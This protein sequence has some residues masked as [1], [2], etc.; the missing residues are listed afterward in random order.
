MNRITRAIGIETSK[1]AARALTA[2]ESAALSRA[3]NMSFEEYCVLQELKSLAFSERRFNLEEAE[4]LY[5]ILGGIPEHFNRQ[6]IAAK[7]VCTQIFMEL[8]T[9]ARK[10]L[11]T[12]GG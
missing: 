2:D 4:T 7:I 10:G 1:L 6:P 12:H 9:I 11:T 8:L 5:G 3:L